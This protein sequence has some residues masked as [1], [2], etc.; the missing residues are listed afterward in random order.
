MKN[1]VAVA[2]LTISQFTAFPF[3]AM[4]AANTARLDEVQRTEPTNVTV[5]YKTDRG[6][7]FETL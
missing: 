5:V 3:L 7:A 4:V 1:L 6:R 2:V